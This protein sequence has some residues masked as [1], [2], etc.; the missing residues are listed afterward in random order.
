M[1]KEY[2][3]EN[4]PRYQIQTSQP[5]DKLVSATERSVMSGMRNLPVKSRETQNLLAEL[6][7]E[8]QTFQELSEAFYKKN[9]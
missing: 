8:L 7:S 9:P 4:D 6:A 3:Y 1:S 5:I 2:K